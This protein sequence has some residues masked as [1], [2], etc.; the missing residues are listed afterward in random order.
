LLRENVYS[1]WFHGNDGLG[2]HDFKPIY[3]TPER[4]DAV[5]KII[6][7]VTANPGLTVVALGPLTNIANA[8]TRNPDV[9][10]GVKR[11]V[12]MGGAPCGRGNVTPVA[13]YN[14]WVDPEAAM[15]VM[16]SGLP[17]ELVGLHLSQGDAA[18]QTNDIH[19]IEQ[20]SNDLSRFAM[21]CTS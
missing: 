10:S 8:I 4:D 5:V 15:K 13:E 3:R 2:D 18:L 7:T 9:I 12:V 19:R 1:H 21:A 14:F 16:C 11:C 6:D 17:I 20:L